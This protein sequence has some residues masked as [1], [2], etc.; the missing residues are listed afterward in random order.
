[1]ILAAGLG[2][3]MRPLTD[4]TPKP[5]LKVGGKPLL[6]YHLEALSEAG[7]HE[8]VINTAYRGEQIEQFA[9]DGQPFGLSIRYSREPEPLETGGAIFQALPLLGEAPFLMI[10]GD[11]WTD[12]PLRALSHPPLEAESQ[13]RLLLVPNPDF[14]PEGDF[15]LTPEH[16]L[17]R[18]GGQESH[19]APRYTF[20][21]ISLLRPE[22]IADYPH[23]RAVFPLLEALLPAVDKG[24]LEG[25][26]HEGRWSD[27]GTPERLKQM[28]IILT[29]TGY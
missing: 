25:R 26:L 10:N 17:S 16:R 22:L 24:Q 27:I 7:I 8:V 9:G 12:Y 29:A 2:K 20:A 18:A 14:H 1:M 3:R 19:F 6:Q 23:R 4:H 11:V 15:A 21:G 5:L 28:D 13:G